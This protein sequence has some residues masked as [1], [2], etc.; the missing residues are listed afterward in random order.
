MPPCWG[1]VPAPASSGGADLSGV[2][3][4]DLTLPER[5][6]TEHV[7]AEIEDGVLRVSLAKKPE[8]KARKIELELGG[9]KARA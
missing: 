1:A 4:S 6:D 8:A 3:E 5:V 9:G 2:A 7:Q